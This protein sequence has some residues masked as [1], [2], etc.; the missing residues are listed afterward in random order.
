MTWLLVDAM[1]VVGSRPDGWWHDRDGAIEELVARVRA[2][3]PRLDADRITVVADGRGA[4]DRGGASGVETRWAGGGTDAADDLI[5]ELLR[6]G[7]ASATVVTADR[8]LRERVRALGAG[9]TGP[10]AFQDVLDGP[11]GQSSG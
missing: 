5:V 8:R 11:D 2:A 1:N 10:R 7:D 3:A 9:V 6:D 4:D